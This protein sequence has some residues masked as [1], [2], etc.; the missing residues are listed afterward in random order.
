MVKSVRKILLFSIPIIFLLSCSISPTYSRKDIDKVIKN[1]CKEEFDLDVGAWGV[2]DTTWI[3]AHFEK[4]LDEN[5]QFDKAVTENIRKIFLSLRR[6][7]LSIEKPPKF[8][9]FVAS[10]IKEMGADLY[11]IG[12]IPDMIKLQ[13]NLISLNESQEREVFFNFLNP[14]A[15]GDNE[16]KHIQKYDI[17]M[18]EFISY[19]VK[20]SIERKFTAPEVK[21]N[22]QVNDLRAYYLNGKLGIIFDIMIKEYKE[23]LPEPFEEAK[24]A[25][26][27]FLKIYD[28]SGDIVE[29]EIFDTFNKK[30]RFYSR[31]AL[32]E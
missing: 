22:F 7:I 2:G 19:L 5:N 25:V 16:G 1:I 4:L 3:Y 14:Q 24:K 26:K 20:Q 10:D 32:F 17:T 21:D 27:K 28:S 29:I 8:Y 31:G 23:G 6:V 18:G 30:R 12:F 11:Y 13:M 9:C 15:I